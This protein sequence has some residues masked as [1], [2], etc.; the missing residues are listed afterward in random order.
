MATA[1]GVTKYNRTR[2]PPKELFE[3][4]PLIEGVFTYLSYG[5]LLILGHISDFL[6]KIGLK[7]VK[8]YTVQDVSALAAHITIVM[9]VTFDKGQSCV[10]LYNVICTGPFQNEFGF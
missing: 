8:G 3:D 10:I 9:E 5:V 7:K 1:N 6:V 2:A 4:Y